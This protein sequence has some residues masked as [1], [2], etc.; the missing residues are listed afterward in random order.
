MKRLLD[1]TDGIVSEFH[2]DDLTDKTI[3]NRV[4]DAEPIVENNKRLQLSSDGYTPS[5]DMRHVASIPL[6]IWERWNSETSGK[7][8][9]GMDRKEKALFLRRKLNDPEFR[10]LRTALGTM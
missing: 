7:L 9:S 6:V 5:R 10:W 2:Y 3:I 8:M 4:Q 1:V